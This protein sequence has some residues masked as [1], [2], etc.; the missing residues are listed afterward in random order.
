MGVRIKGLDVSTILFKYQ[1]TNIIIMVTQLQMTLPQLI[2]TMV[3]NKA[4]C[5]SCGNRLLTDDFR[6]PITHH[7]KVGTNHITT[8]DQDKPMWFYGKCK[9]CE[10]Q[11]ALW[12]MVK[13]MIV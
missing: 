6:S 4:C 13:G 3:R 2:Q 9:A 7:E 5:V 10:Y 11:S 12:K 1:Y 8:S